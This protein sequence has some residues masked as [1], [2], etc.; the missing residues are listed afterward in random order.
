MIPKVR[1]RRTKNRQAVAAA[2]L[3]RPHGRHWAYALGQITGLRE[4][5]VP[6]I[7]A[8]MTADGWLTDS[9]E[10]PGTTQGRPARHYYELTDLGRERLRELVASR[11]DRRRR[12]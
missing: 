2:L 11:P 9:W 6:P 4:G 3:Q 10:E 8:A 12:T 1:R 7:L 5:M